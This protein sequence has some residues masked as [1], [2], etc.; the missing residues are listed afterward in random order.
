MDDIEKQAWLLHATAQA[1]KL[2]NLALICNDYAARLTDD[3]TRIM[4][5]E[6]TNNADNRANGRIGEN[7]IQ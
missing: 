6:E 1:E 3:L 7:A 5:E 2:A 4:R